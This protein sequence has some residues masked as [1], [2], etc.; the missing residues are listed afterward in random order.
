MSSAS[1][2]KGIFDVKS[3]NIMY[4]VF[5]DEH[6][7]DL[8]VALSFFVRVASSCVDKARFAPAAP[9]D[10]GSLLRLPR[11]SSRSC[12]S[13]SDSCFRS[14]SLLAMFILAL[15]CATS[16]LRCTKSAA[17]WSICVLNDIASRRR[18]ERVG[19][20]YEL[21]SSSDLPLRFK[22]VISCSR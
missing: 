22:Y 16:C 13:S 12:A 2:L 3:K 6:Y 11:D 20:T 10:G 4:V 8:A 19:G 15:R 18:S 1:S 17:I 21:I 7:E 14:S 9:I 5:V